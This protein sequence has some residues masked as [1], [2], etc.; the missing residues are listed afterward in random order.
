VDASK[1]DIAGQVAAYYKARGVAPNPTSVQYWAQKWGE[2]GAKDPAYFNMRLAQADEFG[3]G[4]GQATAPTAARM[5]PPAP[6]NL[7]A[8]AQRR[9]PQNL[10][11]ALGAYPPGT[12][13]GYLGR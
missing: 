7:G 6:M 5:A 2:F 12:I 8:M 10:T 3:G 1:G 13:G 9:L 4:G 11:P